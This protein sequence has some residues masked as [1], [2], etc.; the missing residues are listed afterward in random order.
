M[1]YTGTVI[2]F[3]EKLGF[4]FIK[5]DSGGPDV[6]FDLFHASTPFVSDILFL[7]F[8]DNGE[9]IALPKEGDSIIYSLM[10][11]KKG[12]KAGNWCYLATAVSAMIKQWVR[13]HDKCACGHLFSEHQN[14]NT[15]CTKC[16]CGHT[17]PET[18]PNCGSKMNG[19]EAHWEC[20]TCGYGTEEFD[21]RSDDSEPREVNLGGSP[22]SFKIYE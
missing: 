5:P 9:R 16:E 2:W 20:S 19:S 13:A 11:A 7:R 18:C 12:L 15:W 14:T 3:D 1:F 6:M 22:G 8:L 10:R 4:G 21:H 17:Q